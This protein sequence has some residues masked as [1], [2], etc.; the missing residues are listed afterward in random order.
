MKPQ[1][2]SGE[3]P[4]LSTLLQHTPHE[5]R[6]AVGVRLPVKPECFGQ[7]RL[8][9]GI[10]GC[11]RRIAPQRVTKGKALDPARA[12]QWY[13][14]KMMSPERG[15]RL[16]EPVHDLR[17]IGKVHEAGLNQ[18]ADGGLGGLQAAD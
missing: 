11:E 12:A 18:P 10:L 15:G 13:E 7:P 9:G 8:Q 17:P 16:A 2:S 5:R 4:N 6:F 1:K 3:K 14:M